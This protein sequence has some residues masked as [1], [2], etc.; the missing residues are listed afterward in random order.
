[1]AAADGDPM[2]SPRVM[3]D[4]SM[5]ADDGLE[6]PAAVEADDGAGGGGMAGG[7]GGFGVPCFLGDLD[8]VL[9]L[10]F[11]AAVVASV[12]TRPAARRRDRLPPLAGDTFAWEAVAAAA[13]PEAPPT[14]VLAAV[15]VN[16]SDSCAEA[17]ASFSSTSIG[18]PATAAAAA[19]WPSS[20]FGM[21]WAAGRLLLL[22]APVSTL[23]SSPR[24]HVGISVAI[25]F[26]LS[27]SASA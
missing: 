8:F 10:L 5:T 14:G 12:L 24:L 19:A 2:S 1:M 15:P 20:V 26:P 17:A 18:S 6:L 13:F 21:D 22:S 23:S 4:E 25:I 16:D 11:R 3:L 27:S 7:G 9:L